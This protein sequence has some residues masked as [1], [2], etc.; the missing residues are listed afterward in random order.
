V[1]L[2]WLELREFRNHEHTRC[3]DMPDAMIAVVGPNGHGKTNLLEGMNMLYAL[4]SPRSATTEPIVRR[5]AEIA[6]A[7]GEFAGRDGRTLV[8]VEVRRKGA[9]RV[10]VDRSPVR[11]KRDVRANVRVVLFGPFDLPIVIGDPAKRRAFVDEVVVALHPARDQLSTA[12][13]RVVR[14]RNRLLKE[15]DGTGA[16]AGLDA[17]DQQLVAAGVA[18]IGARQHAVDAVAAESATAF[19]ALGGGD[20]LV[21]YLPNVPS[22]G[23]VEAAFTAALAE[24]RTDELTRRACLVGP[25]RDDLRLDVRE[26]GARGTGSHGETWATALSLRLGSASAIE[27]TIGEPPV[28][29]LDDPFSALDPS[30]RDRLA[31]HLVGR[32]GQVVVTVADEADVPAGA[33]AVWDVAGGRV[34]EREAA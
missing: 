31:S 28:L 19:E 6:Y 21:G 12:Y 18:L 20:L 30:R 1:H 3:G 34:S 8:E 17:W 32:G 10:Q 14:Q 25:H 11:R 15:W 2:A 13:D 33:A 4:S 5:D 9:N 29:L 27:A 23:D 24:R 22:S 26:M 16:P 7:R